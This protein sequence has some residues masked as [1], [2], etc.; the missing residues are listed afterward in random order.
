MHTLHHPLRVETCYGLRAAGAND[1]LGWKSD[2]MGVY[3][4]PLPQR[5]QPRFPSDL[6]TPQACGERLGAVPCV[7]SPGSGMQAPG[8]A[9]R[10]PLQVSRK[11]RALLPRNGDLLTVPRVICR[12]RRLMQ[13]SEEVCSSKDYAQYARLPL[14]GD[15]AHQLRR[16]TKAAAQVSWGQ[17]PG[18][19]HGNRASSSK[20]VLRPKRRRSA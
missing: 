20:A 17:V 16:L 5:V 7:H 14:R 13:P 15:R 2:I 12:L 1:P 11:T 3:T 18:A 10:V 4:L 9:G 6:P 19:I 8:I